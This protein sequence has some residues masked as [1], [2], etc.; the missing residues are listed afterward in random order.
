MTQSG[1]RGGHVLNAALPLVG[2]ELAGYRLRA[3]LGRGGMSVVY[4]AENPR[5]GSTVALKVLAPELCSDDIFRARFLKESRI[6]ASLNHPNVIPIFDAGPCDGLLYIAMRYVGGSDLRAVLKEHKRISPAQT[7]LLLGQTGRGLDAAHR[8]GL[9]HRD[10]KPANILIERGAEDDPDHVYLA[11]FGITKHALSHS[12][13]TA[14]GQFVGTIDY[15]APEQIRDAPVDGRADIY[16]LACVFYQCITGRVPFAKDLDA[17]V[18]WAHVE[19]LPTAPSELHPGLPSG[20]D[21]VLACALAKDPEDRYASCREFIAA[22]RECLERGQANGG[23]TSDV[24]EAAQARTVLPPQ[25]LLPHPPTQP[26]LHQGSVEDQAPS[27]A[28]KAAASANSAASGDAIPAADQAA[29]AGA[30]GPPVSSEP[31]PP[32]APPSGSS[33]TNPHPPRRF[34]VLASV[35]A[36]L[37]A[38]MGVAVWQLLGGGTHAAHGVKRASSTANPI[39]QAL[40]RANE[41]MTA[42]GLLPPSSCKAQSQTLVSCV[43]PTF[44]IENATFQTFSSLPALYHAYGRTVTQLSNGHLRT[45]YGECTQRITSGEVSWNHNYQHPRGFS[46]AESMSGQLMDDQAAGRVFCTFTNST[47]LLAWTMNDG[48][49]LGMLTGAPHDDAWMW[50]HGVHH[51]ID[52]IGAGSSMKMPATQTSGGAM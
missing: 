47:Y 51:A 41:S 30:A 39:L 37:L 20:I 11:D 33:T 4:E 26:P 3:V 6:A 44:A 46:L 14:T 17:A 23:A 38:G 9:V 45:N 48:H 40:Q 1:E 10:V 2:E 52:L 25:E 5:L 15:I 8:L 16:S 28:P 7:L 22:A 31:P 49:L 19:E 24:L 50:W 32:P 18:I 36:L 35:A 34:V 43:Q 29:K 13:L 27:L 21:A 42:N 12:G